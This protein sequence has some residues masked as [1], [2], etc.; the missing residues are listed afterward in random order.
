MLK[1]LLKESV[2]INYLHQIFE[3][4]QLVYH[5]FVNTRNVKIWNMTSEYEQNPKTVLKNNH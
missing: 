2:K 1:F 5:T 4:L 3:K